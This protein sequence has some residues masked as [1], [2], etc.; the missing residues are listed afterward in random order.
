[1]IRPYVAADL[2]SLLDVWYQASLIAHAFLPEEFLAAE[3]EDIA[4]V[5]MPVAETIVYEDDGQ[6]VGFLS[7]VGN[8]VGAIFVHPEHQGRGV[9]RALMVRARAAR[10]DL[11]LDVFE[12]NAI[13]RRF[14]DA[15][16]FTF[17][18][19]HVHDETGR[20][21]LRL[22]LGG[23]RPPGAAPVSEDG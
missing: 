14:Y 1:M 5:W 13:G 22:R 4:D 21:Q 17:V 11:E 8:E 3:R 20:M 23:E 16:G 15:Y 9:G 12:A 19:R 7:L 10:P 6:V 2:E 18:R